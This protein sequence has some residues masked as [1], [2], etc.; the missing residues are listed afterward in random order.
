MKTDQALTP[1]LADLTLGAGDLR[2]RILESDAF[3]RTVIDVG[4]GHSLT[5]PFAR[6]RRTANSTNCGSNSGCGGDGGGGGGGGGADRG[7]NRPDHFK[8]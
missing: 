1:N 7:T 6:E 2:S 3:S 5:A 4:D 8:R